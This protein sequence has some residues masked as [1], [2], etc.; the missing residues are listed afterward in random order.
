LGSVFRWSLRRTRQ[1]PRR[2]VVL[3]S[4]EMLSQ[5]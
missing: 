5:P 4:H 1:R 2:H 3:L